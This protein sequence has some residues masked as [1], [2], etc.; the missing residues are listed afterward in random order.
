[1]ISLFLYCCTAADFNKTEVLC[2]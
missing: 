2:R 1:M